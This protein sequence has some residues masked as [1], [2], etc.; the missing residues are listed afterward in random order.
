M[1]LVFNKNEDQQINVSLKIAGKQQAF[2]YINMIKALIKSNKLDKPEIS[3]GFS[4]AEIRSITSMVALI[5]KEISI[6]KKS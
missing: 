4:D 2:S 1:K 6:K 3:S 5:N